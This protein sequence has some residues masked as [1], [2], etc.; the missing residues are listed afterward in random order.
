MKL[1]TLVPMFIASLLLAQ[2][3]AASPR[4]YA[5]ASVGISTADVNY[6]GL[7]SRDTN[8]GA[9]ALGL[10]VTLNKYVALEARYLN[11]GEY[12]GSYSSARVDMKN[13]GYGAGVLGMLP[14][15]NSVSVYGRVDGNNM[16][17]RLTVNDAGRT[18]SRSD[19]S[20]SLGLG[21]GVQVALG[22]G[23]AMRAQF[24]RIALDTDDTGLKGGDAHIKIYSLGLIK[25]F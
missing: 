19:T 2:M 15:T 4:V 18:G 23:L 8:D 17:T 25:S 22:L 10:G 3:A 1:T 14:L 20:M 12:T 7:L 24:E 13:A 11:A 6:N 9:Y 16:R 21:T 5:L